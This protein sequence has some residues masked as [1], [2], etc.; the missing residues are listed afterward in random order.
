[1]FKKLMEFLD[2]MAIGVNVEA[3]KIMNGSWF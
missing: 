3:V 2:A 1:M